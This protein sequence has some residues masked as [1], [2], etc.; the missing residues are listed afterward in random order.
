MGNIA[1]IDTGIVIL[2]CTLFD[3]KNDLFPH[4]IHKELKEID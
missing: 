4:K 2:R 1:A 3:R